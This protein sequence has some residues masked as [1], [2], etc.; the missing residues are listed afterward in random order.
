MR[1]HFKS[2]LGRPFPA[3]PLA[4]M[5]SVLAL[6]TGGRAQEPKKNDPWVGEV[7]FTD[8]GLLKLTLLEEQIEITTSAG[9]KTVRLADLHK[10]ELAL[11]LSE[12]ESK[13]IDAAIRGL[14]SKSFRER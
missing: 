14:S 7:H 8:G 2:L 5:V 13:A 1:S 9:K 12:D 11:R 4:L 6:H 10:V 3:L